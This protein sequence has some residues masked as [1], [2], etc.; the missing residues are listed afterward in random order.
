MLVSVPISMFYCFCI[1]QLQAARAAASQKPPSP[2]TEGVQASQQGTT[3][4]TLPRNAVAL[5][6]LASELSH[7]IMSVQGEMS[8]VRLRYGGHPA[9]MQNSP[10]SFQ[11]SLWHYFASAHSHPPRT[12]PQETRSPRESQ[13]TQ[14]RRCPTPVQATTPRRFKGHTRSCAQ[15]SRA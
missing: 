5:V 3:S 2:Q 8:S 10:G 1:G 12:G 13:M 6:R 14:E 11:Y 9:H 7:K 4:V 15:S